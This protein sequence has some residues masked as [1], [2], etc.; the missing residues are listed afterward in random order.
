MSG[1]YD[2]DA[3]IFRLRDERDE[4]RASVKDLTAKLE[5]AEAEG[6]RDTEGSGL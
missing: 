3:D 2:P 6:T 5:K 1:I 4:L